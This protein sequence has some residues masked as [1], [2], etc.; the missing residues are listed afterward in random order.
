MSFYFPSKTQV[1]CCTQT[2]A[3]A[4]YFGASDHTRT[5]ARS[6]VPVC[7]L[8][9]VGEAQDAFEPQLVE[10]VQNEQRLRIQLSL[11]EVLLQNNNTDQSDA[12]LGYASKYS[13]KRKNARAVHQLQHWICPGGGEGPAFTTPKTIRSSWRQTVRPFP[14][15]HTHIHTHTHTHT[16][17]TDQ[18]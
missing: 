7:S 9:R 4:H 16:H 8:D 11:H 14:L 13:D 6:R 5:H 15:Q 3:Q 2:C 18:R 17:T 10:K 12:R 1:N